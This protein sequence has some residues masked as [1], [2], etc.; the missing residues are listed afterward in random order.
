MFEYRYFSKIQNRRQSKEVANTHLHAK[1]IEKY[2]SLNQASQ[3]YTQYIEDQDIDLEDLIRKTREGWPRLTV[4][5]VA[6][7]DSKSTNERVPSLVGSLGL[8]CR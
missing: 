2:F 7:G 1:N 6:N 3:K 4:D 8:S 5:T